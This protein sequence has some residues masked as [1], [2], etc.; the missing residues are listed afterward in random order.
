MCGIAGRV[1]ALD[2]SSAPIEAMVATLHHRGPDDRGY[3]RA[4]GVELGM[5]RLA[6][7]DV[8]HGQQPTHDNSGAITAIFNGEIYNYAELRANLITEGYNFKS[9]G[10]C[11]VIANLY[12]RYG[13]NFVAHL[14]GMFAIAIWDARNA[15]LLLI[16]D[17]V[18][19]KPLLYSATPSGLLFGSE[20]R[21]LIA[22]GVSRDVDFSALNDVL[23]F[24]YINS[25]RTIYRDIRALPPASILSVNKNGT[26]IENYWQLDLAHKAT[27]GRDES[28]ERMREALCD[29]VQVRTTFERKAGAYLSGGVDSSLVTKY[30]AE[31]SPQGL[32]TYSVRFAESAYDE[33]QFAAEV[34]ACVGTTHHTLDL[35]VSASSLTEVLNSL[36]QPFADSSY[37]ATYQLNKAAKAHIVVAFGGDGGDEAMAGYDR[38]RATV[39]LQKINLLLG[40]AAPLRPLT[41]KLG[42]RGA[43]LASQLHRERSLATRYLSA[44][45]LNQPT[46]MENLLSPGIRVNTQQ[47][48]VRQMELV[49]HLDAVEQLVATD[50]ATYLPGD[51]MVKADWASMTHGV[52]LRSPLLDHNFLELCAQI[53]TRF[54]SAPSGG[55]LLLK[56]LATREISGID[57]HRSKMGFGIPRAQWLRGPFLPVVEEILLSEQC[58]NRGWF[59]PG[60]VSEV[61]AQH[62][63]GR[64]LDHIIWPAL[65]I[66]SWAQN[67]L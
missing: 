7:V 35:E 61:I 32:N 3:F 58:R 65:V 48:F 20:A 33:S 62:K 57:F 2:G 19:K 37:F 50:F 56:E 64:D 10:D 40:L 41:R 13:K 47:D 12:H 17:R 52:E 60:Y 9:N 22:A 29:A 15:T 4:P 18:G 39:A 24:G 45:S 51:L 30:L 14:R 67:W 26:T 34:A 59:N 46:E 16:R 49:G 42:R 6:I 27:W 8:A 55:K 28:L 21:A 66:E 63:A 5:A 25:P 11:E 1:G 38:Y 54:R 53:P 36:D 44:I 23:A 43:R 31:N